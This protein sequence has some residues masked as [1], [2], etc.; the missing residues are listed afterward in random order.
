MNSAD[1]VNPIIDILY[2]IGK[3]YRDLSRAV[4]GGRVGATMAKREFFC[5][6]ISRYV[7]Y[8]RMDSK[9]SRIC[10]CLFSLSL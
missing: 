9:E 8:R 10:V 2:Y 3:W 6:L 1:Y 4:G 7:Y 5:P